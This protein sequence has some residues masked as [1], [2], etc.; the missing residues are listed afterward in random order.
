MS[1]DSWKDK[2]KKKW[3]PHVHCNICGKAIPPDRRFCS[4]NCRDKYLSYELKQKK[5]GR[6]QLICLFAMMGIMFLM[7]F[8]IPPG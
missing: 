1:R 8:M 3:G 5:R 4:Q 6:I 2:I 7:L